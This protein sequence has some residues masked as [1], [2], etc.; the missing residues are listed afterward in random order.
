ME[1]EEILRR[2]QGQKPGKMDEMEQDILNR[3]CKFSVIIGLVV[4]LVMMIAKMLAGVC[5]YDVY[6][7][8]CCMAGSQWLYKWRRL[9][10]KWALACGMMWYAVGLGFFVG[11]LTEIF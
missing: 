1:K 9:K 11:Y 3:G 2:V 5:Y 7:I 10:E 4:C 6:A 8:Y